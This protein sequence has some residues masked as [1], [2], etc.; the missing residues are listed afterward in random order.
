LWGKDL[1]EH[2]AWV[3]KDAA[4]YCV[5]FLSRHYAKKLWAN[6]E[7]KNAQARAFREQKEYI[8]PV[9][10]DDTEIPGIPE[11]IGYVDSRKVSIEQICELLTEKL[12]LGAS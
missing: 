2:L 1:Y 7:R 3:Y 12:N 4:R 5:M 8:L 6:H 9:R 10:I 11:T